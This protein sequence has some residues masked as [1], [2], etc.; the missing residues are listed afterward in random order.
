MI[1]LVG[2]PALPPDAVMWHDK[3]VGNLYSLSP[4]NL[5][6]DYNPQKNS[7]SDYFG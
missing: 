5:S 3:R 6:Y 7:S 1:G 4:D 2:S